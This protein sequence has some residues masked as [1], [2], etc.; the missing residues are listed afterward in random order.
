[1][2]A[3][4]LVFGTTTS[5]GFIM[6]AAISLAV[7]LWSSLYNTAF[8]WLDWFRHR[9]VASDRPTGLRVVHAV[10]HEITSMLVTLPLLIVLGGHSFYAAL[11]TDIALT[12]FYTAYTFV[13]HLAYDRWRPVRSGYD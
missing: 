5:D 6:I 4:A 7:M 8:D 10:L 13:F 2:P 9:R 12:L 3:Y 11:A 1:M